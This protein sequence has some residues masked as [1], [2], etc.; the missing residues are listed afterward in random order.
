MSTHNICFFFVEKEENIN[1]LW[2]VKTP[3]FERLHTS[4]P[5]PANTQRRRDV[6]T[7]SLQRQDVAATL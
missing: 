5:I 3:Y 6:V 1:S 7:T 4:R 2:H